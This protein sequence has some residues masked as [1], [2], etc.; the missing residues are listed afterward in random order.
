MHHVHINPIKNRMY[1]ILKDG[2][3]SDIKAYVNAIE[4][5]C[6]DL[7]YNFSC[8]VVLDKKG[9]VRQSEIDLLFNTVD[10]IYAYGAD[11]IILVRKNN[12]NSDF[13]Q[14]NLLNFKTCFTLENA[15]N[16]QEAENILDQ[17]YNAVN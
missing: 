9:I 5:A 2:N 7:P 14:P 16:I 8:V 13:F 17:R 10:L 4:N 1:I 15:M 11:R 3:T 12:S 6:G